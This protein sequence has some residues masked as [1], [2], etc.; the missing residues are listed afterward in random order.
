[1]TRRDPLSGIEL[2]GK[3]IVGALSVALTLIVMSSLGV[4]AYFIIP[5]VAIVTIL[6]AVWATAGIE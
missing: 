4:S 1:M 6:A 5:A 2:V 3:I